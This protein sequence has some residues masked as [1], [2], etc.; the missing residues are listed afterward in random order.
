[1]HQVVG[2]REYS[3]RDG[4]VVAKI[5]QDPKLPKTSRTPLFRKPEEAKPGSAL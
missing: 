4:N 1:M 2:Y 3:C 5:A